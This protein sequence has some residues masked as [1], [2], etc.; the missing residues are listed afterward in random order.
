MTYIP[1]IL[2]MREGELLTNSVASD[3]E[4]KDPECFNLREYLENQPH[5]SGTPYEST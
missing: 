1:S 4:K 5:Q 3:L 2:Y